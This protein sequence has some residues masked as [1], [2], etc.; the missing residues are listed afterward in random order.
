MGQLVFWGPV[1]FFG[2]PVSFLGGQS[3]FKSTGPCQGL[4][5]H[6]IVHVAV[7]VN[8]DMSLYRIERGNLPC[9]K[10]I[11]GDKSLLQVP[12]PLDGPILEERGDISRS[13]RGTQ[14]WH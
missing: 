1:S 13:H 7:S 9:E 10:E 6:E 8:K 12:A 14:H 4:E 5:R 3:V 2:E 11:P